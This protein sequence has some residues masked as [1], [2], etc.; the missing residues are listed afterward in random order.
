MVR[1]LTAGNP[2]KQILLFSLP[3]LIGNIFQQFYSMVDTIIVGQFLGNSSLAAVGATG[4]VSFFI[5]GFV[6]GTTTGLTVITAKRFGAR[7]HAGV[8]RSI[9]NCF[10]VAIV[11][12]LVMSTLSVLCIRPLMHLLETPEDIFEEAVAYISVICGGMGATIFYNLMAATMRALGDS[13]TPLIFLV[14][15]S[16]LNI[17][18]DLLFVAVLHTGVAGAAWAT[19]ISQVIAGT[20]SL[21]YGLKH[22]E[23]LHVGNIFRKPDFKEWFAHLRVGVPMGLQFSVTAIGSMVLQRAFNL[24]GTPGV[25]AYTAASKVDNLLTQPMMAIGTTMATYAGQNRGAGDYKRLMKGVR[26]AFFYSLAAAGLAM[27]IKFVSGDAFILMFLD[28]KTDLIMEY[29]NT[30][31]LWTMVFYPFLGFVFLFRNTLQGVGETL[32][33][34]LGG[35]GELFARSITSMV[36]PGMVGYL[37]VCLASPIAWITA[38]CMAGLRYLYIASRWKKDPALMQ[39]PLQPEA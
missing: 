35:V 5:M 38:G 20:L 14:V 33:P 32:F 16:V 29:A 37:G 10:Q 7:D 24:F 28:E 1:N 36:L 8:K 17:A 2:A 12:A 15:S 34:M 31:M 3:I 25:A 9:L 23:Y 18:L 30:Y 11:M 27:L 26:I 6:N 21:L 39:G 13:R 19:V 22:N 4:A